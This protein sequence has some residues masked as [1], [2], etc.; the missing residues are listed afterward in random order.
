MT[1]YT[2]MSPK[3]LVI[4]DLII[5]QYLWGSCDRVSPEAPV[6]IIKINEES[7]IL[8]GA[9]NVVNNL[10]KLGAEVDVI[11]VIGD[12]KNSNE[13]I[14]L[15]K[16]IEVNTKYSLSPRYY[17]VVRRVSVLKLK[18]PHTTLHNLNIPPR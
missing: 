3:I 15:L 18:T 4:G 10:K 16:D 7:S 13:L 1:K 6:P 2:N 11:S 17:F 9:G 8:G 5:D 14:N 12:C